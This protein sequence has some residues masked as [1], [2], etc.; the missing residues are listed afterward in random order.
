MAV[1]NIG[2]SRIRPLRDQLILY[3]DNTR[4]SRE[5]Q[6]LI[7]EAGLDPYITYAPVGPL[8]RKPLILYGGGVYQ[9]LQE[10]RGLLALL[11]FWSNQPIKRSIF[12]RNSEKIEHPA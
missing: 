2:K 3:V 8:Q 11:E 1:A 7:E 9:R 4:E 10:I 6:E 12:R 5:A